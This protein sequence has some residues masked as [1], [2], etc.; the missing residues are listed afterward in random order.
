MLKVE[1]K[2]FY[3]MQNIS[4]CFV[5]TLITIKKIISGRLELG[6]SVQ[7]ENLCPFKKKRVS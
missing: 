2:Q 4:F 3:K 5:I 6:I 7:N 1:L